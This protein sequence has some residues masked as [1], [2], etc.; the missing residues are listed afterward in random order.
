MAMTEFG[1]NDPLAVKRW[2][3]DLA[4][5]AEKSMYFRRFMGTGD[6]AMIKVKRDLSK[7]AGD[8]I[9]VGLLMKLSGDGIE[10]DNIIEGTS[11]EEALTFHYMDVLIDQRRKGTKSK[12]KMT[13]QRVPYSIRL[14]G[15]QALQ[16]WWGEDYDEQCMMYLAGA[17]G[18][19]PSF[20]VGLGYTGRAGNTI[21]APDSAHVIYGGNATGLSDIDTADK[22]DV[23]LIEQLVATAE[24]VDPMVQPVTFQ[25]EKKFVLVMHNYQAYD[26][27]TSISQND[28][29]EIHKATDRVGKNK[30]MMYQN[31]LGEYAGVILHKH[32]NVIRF[33]STTGC[34]TGITA[35]RA[36]FLGAQAGCMAWGRGGAFGRYSWNEET[37]DRGNALAIT[38]G[39]MMGMVRTIFNSA[40]FS[41]FALD[42]FARDP[43]A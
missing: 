17:R 23:E 2:S 22:M 4:M 11:A 10:G 13:E 16:I 42:T 41:L 7:A 21:T 36:L 12:G 38:A 18:I 15:R 8:R 40:T 3:T 34:S 14:K 31:A 39:A 24:T 43:A 19:D 28:W 26:L 27:R 6:Q 35:A 37:D 9:R 20:H 1:V 32:R 5:E 25:G 33:D 29:L 30:P